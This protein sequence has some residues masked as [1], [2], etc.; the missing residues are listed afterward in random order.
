[1]G[2]AKK[3]NS[4]SHL[5][6]KNNQPKVIHRPKDTFEEENFASL[7]NKTFNTYDNEN[8][9]SHSTPPSECCSLL[10]KFWHKFDII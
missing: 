10:E 9:A 5:F 3:K 4:L 8:Y 6:V 2:V 1:M 7:N